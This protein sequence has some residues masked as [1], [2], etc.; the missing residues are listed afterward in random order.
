VYRNASQAA[1]GVGRYCSRACQHIGQTK[2]PV[3]K[4]CA[5][6]G[7]TMTL[8]PSQAHMQYCSKACDGAARVKRPLLQMHNG[9][10]AK[11]DQHGYVM[12]WEPEHPNRTM[13]G[14]QYEHRLVAET[15][16]GRYLRSDEHVHHVNGIKN[17]NRIENLDVMDGN[18]HAVLTGHEYRDQ[19]QRERAE[20]AAYRKRYGPLS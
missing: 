14:W 15:A 4:A 1:K 11:L 18:D 17:D 20:L 9:R 7:A 12:V 16:V 8:K 19:L 5:N 2:T 13:K 6:C 3:V 10:P